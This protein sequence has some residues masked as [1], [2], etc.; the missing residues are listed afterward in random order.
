MNK[1]VDERR[2][3]ERMD[4]VRNKWDQD[5][6]ELTYAWAW[7]ALFGMAGLAVLLIYLWARG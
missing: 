4:K 1:Q 5:E 6:K 7:V 3:I 2:V